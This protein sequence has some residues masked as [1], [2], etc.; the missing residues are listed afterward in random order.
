M[1]ISVIRASRRIGYIWFSSLL[2]CVFLAVAGCSR[3]NSTVEQQLQGEWKEDGE[4]F[5]VI[6]SENH[7]GTVDFKNKKQPFAWTIL[8]DGRIQ[9]TDPAQQIFYL[10]FSGNKLFIEGTKSILSRIK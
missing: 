3:E 5:Y 2:V 9:V 7:L 1:K 4:G 10:K 6:F 8:E